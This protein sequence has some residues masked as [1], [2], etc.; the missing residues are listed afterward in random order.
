MGMPNLPALP[1][2]PP[3]LP[4]SGMSQ[5]AGETAGETV[6][7]ANGKPIDFAALLSQLGQGSAA[8]LTLDTA[9]QQAALPQPGQQ[10]QE[11]LA[12]TAGTAI[13]ALEA[14][15][16]ASGISASGTYLASTTPQTANTTT[17]RDEEPGTPLN[18]DSLGTSPAAEILALIGMP[19]SA[20]PLQQTT[21]AEQ[22]PTDLMAGMNPDGKG[23]H[24]ELA[25]LQQL[26]GT[27]GQPAESAK[28]AAEPTPTATNAT[29]FSQALQSA[30]PQPNAKA[31]A[32]TTHLP[33]PVHDHAWAQ[34]FGERVTWLA[35]Q[36]IQAA[37][38]TLNPPQLGPIQ[39]ALSLNGDQAT[40][41]FGVANADVRQVVENSL[42]QLREMLAS[43]GIQL[44]DANVG[45]QLPQQARDQAAQMAGSRR[46]TDENAILPAQGNTETGVIARA[47]RQG[48]GLVDL[49]A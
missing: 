42:P 45:A 35:K 44:G 38:I 13:A 41:S 16:S 15:L 2:L 21:I 5:M 7:D 18:A 20:P 33:T 31:G 40:A 25:R 27:D 43:A 6:L 48:S 23:Q 26:T 11:A 19:P 14:A 1:T 24:A 34:G 30:A 12:S 49:F 3:A 10:N 46:G 9:Q 29:S 39:I 17:A 37:Q 36:D 32:H 4:G 28:I 47:T 8:G 22:P